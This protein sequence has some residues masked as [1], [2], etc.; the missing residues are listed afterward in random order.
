MA[1][2]FEAVMLV[3]F[4]VSWPVSVLKSWRAGSSKGKSLLFLLLIG[5]GYLFG[6]VGKALFRPS[7]VIAVYCVNIFFVSCDTA[8]YFRNR[9]LDRK[10]E[11]AGS[12][13]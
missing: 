5:T 7:W 3:C 8:L 1:E 11:A 9:K 10:R 2:V 4:G 12:P 6:V 13:S